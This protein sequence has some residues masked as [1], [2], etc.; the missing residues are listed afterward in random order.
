MKKTN[1]PKD[2]KDTKDPKNQKTVKRIVKRI[3]P[4]KLDEAA[5]AKLASELGAN[6]DKIAALEE[7]KKAEDKAING[8]IALLDEATSLL[9]DRIRSKCV[10]K[11]VD[12]EEVTDYRAGELRVTRLDTKEVFQRSNLNK[13]EYQLPLD[14]QKPAG[15]LLPIDGGK[16]KGPKVPCQECKGQRQI[17]FGENKLLTK[18]ENCDGEGKVEAKDPLKATL[19]D[20]AATHAKNKVDA[21]AAQGEQPADEGGHPEVEK[22]L[23]SR[24]RGKKGK[25]TD[26]SEVDT[27]PP[28]GLAF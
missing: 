28:D 18:C 11:E 20:V 17:P 1:E 4:C 13:E 2:P 10:E 15:K 9:R 16:G 3:L 14:A 19:G 23:A 5:L 21:D 6:L 8:D 26:G 25:K 22:I 24:K 12:C 7:K 27:T